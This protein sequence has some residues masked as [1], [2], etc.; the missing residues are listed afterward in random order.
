[1]A[2]KVKVGLFAWDDWANVGELLAK[3]LRENKVDAVLY[4]CKRHSFNYTNEGIIV[5][6][7]QGL[8]EAAKTVDIVHFMHSGTYSSKG[9]RVPGGLV[10][11]FIKN[12]I[13]SKNKTFV[14][15]HGG[16]SYR[17][18][19][20]VINK[21]V[22]PYI[23]ATTTQT[24]DLLDLGAKN[25]YWLLPP[26][27]T[28][29]LKP[30]TYV[31]S[32]PIKIAHYPSSL[33]VKN[34]K[35]IRS[36]I[37]KMS[38]ESQYSDGEPVKYEEHINRIHDCDVYIEHQGFH[39]NGKQYGEFGLTGLEAAAL[40]KIVITCTKSKDRYEKEYGEFVPYI[41]NS[42][43]E[44]GGVLE[45]L[46][47]MNSQ[48]IELE[49]IKSRAWVEKNHSLLNIGSRLAKIYMDTKNGK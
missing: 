31:A 15:F 19:S 5:N 35:L 18:Y 1:M 26:I 39:Q 43:E 4:K 12:G 24:Y 28:G 48:E 11:L 40:G 45:K 22:N 49:K 13:F 46:L 36:L 47:L 32:A 29:V 17:Q 42:E 25:E 34:T 33:S 8:I 6:G 37:S 23:H 9:V 2:Y 10:P 7:L 16:T 27:D 3:S 38:L 41:S 14:M 21:T 44:L 20:E 30:K